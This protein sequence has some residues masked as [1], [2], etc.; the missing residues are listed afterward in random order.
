MLA[1]VAPGPLARAA[2]LARAGRRT[3]DADQRFW[4]PAAGSDPEH[5]PA[6]LGG[7]WLRGSRLRFPAVHPFRMAFND[8]QLGDT[9]KSAEREVTIAANVLECSRLARVIARIWSDT[10]CAAAVISFTARA[11]SSIAFAT[12]PACFRFSTAALAISTAAAA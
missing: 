12:W 6:A 8:L 7:R 4:R 11:C 1:A 10:F 3:I 5:A 2:R 9:F